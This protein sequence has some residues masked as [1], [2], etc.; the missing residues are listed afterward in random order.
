LR[1]NSSR[2]RDAEQGTDCS[3]PPPALKFF[4]R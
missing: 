2:Q 3:G 4:D 1:H